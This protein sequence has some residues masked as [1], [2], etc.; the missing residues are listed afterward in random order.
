MKYVGDSMGNWNWDYESER[1]NWVE[2]RRN[3]LLCSFVVRVRVVFKKIVVCYMVVGI[4]WVE[5]F[6]RVEIFV[7][8]CDNRF[9]KIFF[10]WMIK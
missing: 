1:V 3:S 5:V 4:I 9:F 7:I 8:V 2:F 10:I 6:I